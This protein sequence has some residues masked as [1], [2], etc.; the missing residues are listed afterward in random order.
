M[1]LLLTSFK[2]IFPFFAMLFGMIVICHRNEFDK[3]LMFCATMQI[4]YVLK[5][6]YYSRHECLKAIVVHIINKEL[7]R[8]SLMKQT[9]SLA[10]SIKEHLV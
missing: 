3:T 10:T 6:T 1:L 2:S 4:L 7:K 9:T 8:V 5:E